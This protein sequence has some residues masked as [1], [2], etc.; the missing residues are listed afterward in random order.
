MASAVSTEENEEIVR[1]FVEQFINEGNYGVA[2]RFLAE[3]VHDYT[4]L[5]ETTGREAL[6]ETAKEVGTAFP[7]FGIT[8]E[9]IVADGDN[10]AVRMIQ[11][12]THDGVFMG[13]GPTGKSFEIEAMAFL[14]VEDG[15]IVERRTRP[16]IL[17]LLRQ[18]G[19]TELPPTKS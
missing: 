18:L 6:V 19:I 4:P 1:Q 11:R 10:V 8:L 17:G 12:G 7:D 9:E 3:D 15:K 13:I 14:R 16:N 5:G 2:E